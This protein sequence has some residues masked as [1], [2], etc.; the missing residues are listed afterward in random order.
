MAE[1]KNS[2]VMYTDLASTFYELTDIE[3][4]ILIKHIFRYVNDENPILEDRLLNI[5]F[6]QIK[7]KLKRDLVKWEGIKVV[8]SASGRSGG[9]KSGEIRRKQNEANEASALKSKQNEANEAVS[10]NVNVSVSDNVKK[11]KKI[12]DFDLAFNGFLEM[13]KKLKKP[14]TVRAIELV[15]M[16]LDKLAPENELLQIEIINQSTRNSWQDVFPLK[17]QDYSNGVTPII[18]KVENRAT[19]LIN[20]EWNG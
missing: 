15:R 9:I 13:R 7:Q 12:G 10:V 11:E 17:R 3:A 5:V 6:E 16:A 1:N 20:N 2:F 4:G 8:R 18:A 14:A 19:P